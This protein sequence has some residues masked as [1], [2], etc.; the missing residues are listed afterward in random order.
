MTSPSSSKLAGSS[1]LY[2]KLMGGTIHNED[3]GSSDGYRDIFSSSVYQ[4]ASRLD[5]TETTNDKGVTPKRRKVADD[6]TTDYQPG[7]GR[8]TIKQPDKNGIR[9]IYIRDEEIEEIEREHGPRKNRN[10]KDE[11]DK[12]MTILQEDVLG[13]GS[14]DTVKNLHMGSHTIRNDELGMHM[15]C[16]P[17]IIAALKERAK[18]GRNRIR[19]GHM[20]THPRY[21]TEDNVS[22]FLKTPTYMDTNAKFQGLLLANRLK[23]KAP[24]NASSDFQDLVQLRRPH[25]EL[26][27]MHHFINSAQKE[28]GLMFTQL[29]VFDKRLD[30]KKSND[31]YVDEKWY[32]MSRCI[33][34]FMSM[35]ERT[36]GAYV[37]CDLYYEP[38]YRREIVEEHDVAARI[39]RTNNVLASNE[40]RSSDAS[41][42]SPMAVLHRRLSKYFG[43]DAFIKY[44]RITY[45]D[46]YGDSTDD[47]DP[48]GA[49]FDSPCFRVQFLDVGFIPTVD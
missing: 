41:E 40:P 30:C 7:L 9:E 46:L 11:M 8:P 43:V 20:I 10:R 31:L 38:K 35:N 18:G 15:A 29:Y 28:I 34:I 42:E 24:R 14:M 36:Y 6:T 5:P 27:S 23:R 1:G 22:E 12:M 47:R 37:M 13:N 26:S 19:G 32:H 16:I 45:S 33:F 4:N 17:L 39:A 49:V 25:D 44:H 3:D 2:E 21:V 48:L